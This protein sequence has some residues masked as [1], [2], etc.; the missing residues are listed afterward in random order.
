MFL[1]TN[2][3]DFSNPQKQS[4][5]TNKRIKRLTK[6]QTRYGIMIE[7]VFLFTMAESIKNNNYRT[8]HYILC[9][10][11]DGQQLK[12]LHEKNT[13]PPLSVR[14][15]FNPS[16]RAGISDLELSYILYTHKDRLKI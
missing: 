2:I 7:D 16:F 11:T 3:I 4:T 1:K 8:K 10:T 13:Y 15:F 14:L 5:E 6:A 9:F 12:M